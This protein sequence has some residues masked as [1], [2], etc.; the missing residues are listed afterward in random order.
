MGEK[1]A[2]DFGVSP[3][4]SIYKMRKMNQNKSDTVMKSEVKLT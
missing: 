3:L 2:A 1:A 4:K